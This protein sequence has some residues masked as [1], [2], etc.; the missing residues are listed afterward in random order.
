MSD[1][2]NAAIAAASQGTQIA[3][4]VSASRK[5]NKRM[6]EFWRMQNEYNSP[7]AQMQRL[8]EAGLNPNLIYGDSVSGA[9]G[10]ADSIGT[11]DKP[12]TDVTSN[13]TAFTDLRHRKAQADLTEQ[14]VTS[15]MER[16]RLLSNQADGAFFSAANQNYADQDNPL[17]KTQ[18]QGMSLRNEMLKRNII[19]KD[20]ENDIKDRTKAQA[21]ERI[22]W[23]AE[24]AKNIHDGRQLQNALLKLQKQ[25]LSLG[26]DRNSPW[27]AKIF[28]T[29]IN[30]INRQK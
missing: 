12:D 22:F 11:P 16:K 17:V 27:Y 4:D 7:R 14:Q 5:K 9:T 8:Q 18:L 24:N 20:I 6:I 10:R 29:I 25:F 19:G 2:S 30:K 3:Y 21:V 13:I 23:E 1:A 15:E 26:L 28:G